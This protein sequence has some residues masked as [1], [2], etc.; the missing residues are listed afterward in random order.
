LEPIA[1]DSRARFPLVRQLAQQVMRRCHQF[2]LCVNSQSTDELDA[3]A[4]G[5]AD[6]VDMAD[7]SDDAMDADDED[8]DSDNDSVPDY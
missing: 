4:A 7:E 8:D 1:E 6:N 3:V 5:A 2:R